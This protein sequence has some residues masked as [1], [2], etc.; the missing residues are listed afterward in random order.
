MA[1]KLAIPLNAWTKGDVERYLLW[2]VVL[3]IMLV[4]T[5]VLLYAGA[6]GMVQSLL[7][8]QLK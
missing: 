1:A 4:I 2:G 5:L 8:N 6:F 7:L 3:L